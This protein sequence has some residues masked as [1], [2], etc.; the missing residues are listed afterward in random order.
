MKIYF[1]AF[2][3]ENHSIVAIDADTFK[4]ILHKSNIKSDYITDDLKLF[5]FDFNGDNWI[6]AK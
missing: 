6:S 4:T 3:A 1:P 2:V 5:L